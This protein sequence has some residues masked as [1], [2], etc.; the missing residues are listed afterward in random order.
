MPRGTAKTKQTKL[1]QGMKIARDG[2]EWESCYF[3]SSGRGG[4]SGEASVEVIVLPER[5]KRA[6]CK[7][8]ERRGQVECNGKPKGPEAGICFILLQGVLCG[9]SVIK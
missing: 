2:A 1:E 5:S 9:S 7:F 6:R 8:Q 3:K 4:V